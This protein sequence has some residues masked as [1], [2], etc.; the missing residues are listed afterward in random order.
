VVRLV[1]V[2]DS[3]NEGVIFSTPHSMNYCDGFEVHHM[4]LDCNAHN[5]PQYM[6]GQPVQIRIPLMTTSWVESVK[7][8][9][10]E[11]SI[12]R[13]WE[14]FRLGRGT[15][16]DLCSRARSGEGYVTNCTSISNTGTV[17]VL[18]V[19]TNTD[20]L[21]LQL[22]R[23]DPNVDFYS[24]AEIE[25]SG[26]QVSLPSATTSD[27]EESRL[28]GFD[29]ILSTVD[30]N[31][32]TFWV[33]GPEQE[34]EIVLP[35]EPNTP[36]SQLSFEWKCKTIDGIGRLGPA[37]E[38]LVRARDQATG[39]FFSVPIVRHGRTEDGFEAVTFGTTLSTN[40][41][42]TD[43]L[44][45]LLTAKRPQVDYYSL[46]EIGVRSPSTSV[47]MRLP[48]A[49]RALS[50]GFTYG[51]L[52]AFDRSDETEWV[53]DTQGMVGALSLYGSNLKFTDLKISGFGTKA[54]RE[55]FPLYIASFA[56]LRPAMAFGNILIEDCVLT[57]PAT[58]NTDGVGAVIMT[59][60]LPDTLTNAVIRRCTVENLRPYFRSS[61]A[62]TALHVENSLVKDCTMGVYFEP[63]SAPIDDIEP[64]LIRSNAFI[65]VDQGVYVL[66]HPVAQFDSITCL[67]NEIV[68]SGQVGWGFSACD[69]C[70]PG[71]SGSIT[72]ATILNNVIRYA[73]WM[74]RGGNQ[75]GGLHYSDIHHAVFGNNVI[76]LGAPNSLWVR[77]YPAGIIFPP[78]STEDCEGNVFTPPQVVTYPPPVD[79]L[80]PGYR[81]A[82][83]NN[84]DMSGALIDV[85]T[86][87]WGSEGLASQQQWPEH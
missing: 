66:S 80:R 11:G 69:V 48:Y 33:S 60:N 46:S 36:V 77:H 13:D 67:D 2:W 51:V 1:N 23:R 40:A 10:R 65:N 68:L 47:K 85:L 87:R 82:W 9:W 7:L 56:S 8:R 3:V 32:G 20:E 34:V 73:D 12:P 17:D 72:N 61:H 22:N 30:E 54:G 28:T 64:V 37:S 25:V 6:W 78:P 45:I 44:A 42:I 52:R 63:E 26:A 14:P 41:V 39:D 83:F 35:L 18:V 81:R 57:E 50:W 31:S 59:A 71:A 21:V 15:Q 4:V 79:P 55:C 29:S 86:A 70:T 74:P 62:F 58:N 16:F 76:A 19:A 53:S 75:T 24:L 84:Q 27:G 43:R 49:N 38:Y 5:N